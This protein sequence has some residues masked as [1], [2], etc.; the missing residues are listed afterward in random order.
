[1]KL[2][3]GIY[4]RIDKDFRKTCLGIGRVVDIVQDT[5]YIK[6]K[7]MPS[8]SF[9]ENSISK[10]SHKP[11]DLIEE[12]DYVN[13]YKVSKIEDNGKFKVLIMDIGDNQ[14]HILYDCFIEDGSFLEIREEQIKSIVTKEQFEARAYEVE[15]DS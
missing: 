13:G 2:E 9:N 15:N 11:I 7:N 4:V 6:M 12:G 10:A 3:A 1:M 14:E 5:V 8:I